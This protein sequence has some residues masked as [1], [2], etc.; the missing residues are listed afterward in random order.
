L[1]LEGI[2]IRSALGGTAAALVLTLG[3]E[4]VLSAA[5]AAPAKTR[6]DPLAGVPMHPEWGTVT[7]ASGVLK[8]G[9][10]SYTFSY[11]VTPPEGIWALEV[12]VTGPGFKHVAAGAFLDGYDPASGTGSYKLCQPTVRYGRFQIEAKISV[13]DGAGNIVEGRTATDSYRLHRRHH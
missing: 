13:D 3:T 10:H 5:A 1:S 2:V 4:L 9:C 7:G 8:R 6:P 11:T 12:F